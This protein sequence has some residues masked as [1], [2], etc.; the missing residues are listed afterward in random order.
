MPEGDAAISIGLSVNSWFRSS[1][2][3]DLDSDAFSCEMLT[4]FAL[5][6]LREAIE[7]SWAVAK[8]FFP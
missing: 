1:V 7:S 5:R 6:F 4:S 3:V 8:V 2:E